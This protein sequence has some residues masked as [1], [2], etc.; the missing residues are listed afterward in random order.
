MPIG[1]IE[2]EA[3]RPWRPGL[4]GVAGFGGSQATGH[5]PLEL[6]SRGPGPHDPLKSG[7]ASRVFLVGLMSSGKSTVGRALSRR[8]GWPYVDND[9]LVREATGRSA[10]ELE[11]EGGVDALHAAETDAFER[12]LTL[13]APVVVGVAGW[14][15]TDPDLRARMADAGQV[16]WMRARPET[17]VVRAGRGAGRRAAATSGDWI[18]QVAD[19][20]DPLFASIADLVIDVDRRRPREI[21][22]RIVA[23][24]VHRSDTDA[25]TSTDPEG[26]GL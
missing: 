25:L 9:G 1:P 7:R 12:A 4:A 14:I 22:E 23:F 26:T 11:A 19:E 2:R 15:V 3:G 20:R 13:E 24:M 17:L 6:T 16:V 21:V 5:Q 8:T 10:P 18:R